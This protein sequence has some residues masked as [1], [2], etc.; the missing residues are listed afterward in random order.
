MFKFMSYNYIQSFFPP[1]VRRKLF[2][3]TADGKDYQV[4]EFE[5]L[6]NE[7]SSTIQNSTD[8]EGASSEY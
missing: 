1:S 6:S 5:S 2:E 4:S 3:E 7:N 8:A